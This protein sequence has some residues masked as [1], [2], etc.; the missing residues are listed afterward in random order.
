MNIRR[1]LSGTVSA[2]V[3]TVSTLICGCSTPGDSLFKTKTEQAILN[4]STGQNEEALHYA[5]KALLDNP[6]D[7]YAIMIAGLSYES[8]GYPNQARA[9]YEQAVDIDSAG[10]G[11]FGAIRNIPPEDLKKT[12]AARLAALSLPQTQ[13]AVIDPKTNN[14]V[15]TLA[16]F[17][18]SEEEKKSEPSV[19]RET[20]K[21]GLDMLEEGDRNLVL[22]F[23]TFNRLRDEKYVTPDEWLSRRTVNLGGLLPYTLTPAAKGLDLPAPTG[24]VIVGRLNALREAL[25]MRAIT[26]REHAAEREIILEALLPSNPFYRMDAA[27]VPRDI[28]E[29]ATALRRIEMLQNIGL[30]TPEE[31]KKEKEAIEKLTYAKIGM[32]GGDAKPNEAA[33][34]CIQKCLSAPATP[35]SAVAKPVKKSGTPAKRKPAAK[36]KAVAKSCPCS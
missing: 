24:D 20:I 33:A 13:L 8:L 29:G 1:K 5:Q 32:T 23:L 27:P 25:E 7:L 10:I 2:A 34:K 22:R 35:C 11:V 21:G 6:D 17:P 16:G 18:A 36:K 9:M 12:I 14:A 30:I 4:W 15:F 19:S 26:P 31:A 28:L 3:L